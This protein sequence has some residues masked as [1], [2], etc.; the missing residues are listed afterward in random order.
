[1]TP[2]ETGG[3]PRRRLLVATAL[4]VI[5][6]GAGAYVERT[7]PYGISLSHPLGVHHHAAAD[8]QDN[9]AATATRTVERQTL[10]QTTA[11]SGT[12]GYAG[13]YTVLGQAHGTVTWLP[14]VGQVIRERRLLYRVDGDPVVLLY[15]ST[16]AYRDLA[17]GAE[18][19]DVT[20][21]DVRQ[22]NHDLVA[23]G[24]VGSAE[25][26]PK[27][28]E[29]SW[30]TRLGVQRLQDAVGVTATGKLALGRYAFEP[31]TVR[32]TSLSAT[33]GGP[34]GGP[35][36]KGTSTTRQVTV[37]LDAGE[38]SQVKTG[39]AVSITLPDNRSTP[40]KV[41]S[42]STVAATSTGP[43]ATGS[44]TTPTIGVTIAVTNPTTTGT[45]DQAPVQVAI[46]TQTARNVLAV[47]VNALLALSSGGYAVEVIDVD[48]THHL[49]PINVGL[50]DDAAG[51]V[52][53]SGSDLA[54][55]QRV[56][57]PAS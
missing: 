6:A 34:A 39:D 19:A 40:G 43:G 56:V 1:M 14:T 17:A 5:L 10:S 38:Q 3:L 36:L 55:G 23:L 31:G 18:A 26:D 27:S 15:G 4:V 12:L 41:T 21:A 29:F 24:Y 49:I 32:V 57:V 51:L 33:L 45:L 37:N 48:G 53:V 11:V 7:N 50:F 44:A 28:D 30:A 25:L 20:G 2:V 46:T 47:P 54:A 13:D 42:V 16:P 9:G 22:L 8:A 52:Q 35:I